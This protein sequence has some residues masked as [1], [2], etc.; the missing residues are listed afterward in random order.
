MSEG[1]I[2]ESAATLR[3]VTRAAVGAATLPTGTA[4]FAFPAHA[5]GPTDAARCTPEN[6]LAA[7][8]AA[9]WL[10]TWAVVAEKFRFD[11]VSSAATA[12][13]QV[14]PDGPGLKIASVTV[15][16]SLSIR[17]IE[18]DLDA[19][20]RKACEVSSRGCIVE[21]ALK[22]GVGAYTVLPTITWVTP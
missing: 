1:W 11:V 19:K 8:A 15:E 13:V 7:S 2:D 10:L 6:L 17:G 16:V 9:C 3:G 5:G 22:P 21:K 20:V 18:R 12:K 14:V 4:E